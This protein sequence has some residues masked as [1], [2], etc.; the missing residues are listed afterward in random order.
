MSI[1][2]TRVRVATGIFIMVMATVLPPIDL[3]AAEEPAPA[4]KSILGDRFSLDAGMKFWVAKW[5]AAGFANG[6]SASR[7]SDTT[8]LMGP[9]VTGS[10]RLRD[11][12][13]FNRLSVN[14]TWLQAGGFDF[15]SFGNRSFPEPPTIRQL[16]V[17]TTQSRQRSRS[18]AG[19]ES[20]A[21]TTT[22]S[23]DSAANH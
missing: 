22:C 8:A 3:W 16:L 6:I 19:S 7:T 12:E 15:S 9:S 17:E 2:G 21:A 13:L 11:D 4:N 1:Q 5:Q 10:F 20:S 14:F 18:G 23:N